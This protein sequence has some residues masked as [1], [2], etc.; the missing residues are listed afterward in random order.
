M[1]N[2]L[3]TAS[4]RRAVKDP[5]APYPFNCATKEVRFSMKLLRRD[6]YHASARFF[7]IKAVK[8]QF[9]CKFNRTSNDS[10]IGFT[11]IN[12]AIAEA[13]GIPNGV[14]IML[15]IVSLIRIGAPIVLILHKIDP[16]NIMKY[17]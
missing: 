7:A 6:I 4:H 14:N 17:P 16:T 11:A 10:V 15:S 8:I 13:K 2:F 12:M 1:I 3:T 5:D 9:P